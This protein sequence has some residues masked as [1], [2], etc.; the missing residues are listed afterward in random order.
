MEPV[1]IRVWDYR[2][3]LQGAKKYDVDA[4]CVGGTDG[5]RAYFFLDGM[6]YEADGDDGHWWV[7]SVSADTWA[8]KMLEALNA[9]N[10]HL[11][12]SKTDHSGSCHP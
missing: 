1:R 10:E 9:A 11:K 8:G 12:Q 6:L 4:W 2:S 7:K 5:I 3:E